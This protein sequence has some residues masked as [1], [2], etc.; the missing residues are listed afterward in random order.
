MSIK[1]TYI[2]AN[3]QV[4]AQHD[5]DYE[6]DRYFYLHDRLGSVRQ[7]INT[8]GDVVNRYT[9]KPFGEL[10]EGSEH[11]DETITNPFGFTGQYYDSEIEQY[12]LRARQYDPHL[13]IFTSIDPVLG[14]FE[15]PLTLHEYL[16]CL[17]D[18]LNWIDTTGLHTKPAR[19][20]RHHDTEETLQIIEDATELLG[21]WWSLDPWKAFGPIDFAFD[22]K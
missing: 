1:K 10:F 9:F 11:L 2:Y 13:Q 7:I 19:E 17:N 3:S 6:A 18:P 15:E 22:Y 20:R 21:R 5:G 4:I 14:R 16:Y 8:N 12:Y